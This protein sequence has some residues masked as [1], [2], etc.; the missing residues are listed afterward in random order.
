[1]PTAR[2][3]GFSFHQ[4][5]EPQRGEAKLK[6]FADRGANR[7]LSDLRSRRIARIDII[8]I[9][10]AMANL[11]ACKIVARRRRD[12]VGKYAIHLMLQRYMGGPKYLAC[13]IEGAPW[14]G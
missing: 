2:A 6:A 7:L 5:D 8:A 12:W 10:M 14:H 1:M 9:R 4:A 13:L 11:G 3:L